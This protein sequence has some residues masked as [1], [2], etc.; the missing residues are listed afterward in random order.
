MEIFKHFN[1]LLFIISVTSHGGKS[2]KITNQT[3]DPTLNLNKFLAQQ[4]N[5]FPWLPLERR[6]AKQKVT[7]ILSCISWRPRFNT[8]HQTIF[9]TANLYEK[10]LTNFCYDRNIAAIG[11]SSSLHSW[12]H[13]KVKSGKSIP[14]TFTQ[15]SNCI[16]K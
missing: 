10:S 9:D 8:F 3:S 7:Y 15:H 1:L 4:I 5:L 13:T 12:C 11:R 14:C 2:Q 16:I 6:L